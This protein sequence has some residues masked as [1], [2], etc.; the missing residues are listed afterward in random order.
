MS[1]AAC[2]LCAN[3]IKDEDMLYSCVIC[4]NWIGECCYN[5]TS[6]IICHE[7][8][9]G[10]NNKEPLTFLCC[11]ET[12]EIL[13]EPDLEYCGVCNKNPVCSHNLNYGESICLFTVSDM[14]CQKYICTNC[15]IKQIEKYDKP[16]CKKHEP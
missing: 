14:T 5:K 1:K 6:R 13:Y 15:Y 2:S 16:L 4:H 3:Q 7:S 8:C 11:C 9:Q 10:F 12:C